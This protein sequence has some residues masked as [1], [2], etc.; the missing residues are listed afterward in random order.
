MTVKLYAYKDLVIGALGMPFAAHNDA[1]A[2]RR[3]KFELGKVEDVNIKADTQLFC[4]GSYDSI[5]GSIV[6]DFYYI[7]IGE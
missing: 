3:A 5:T 4:L 2:I 7:E 6:P 1:E